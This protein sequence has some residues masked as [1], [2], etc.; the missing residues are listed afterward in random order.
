MTSNMIDWHLPYYGEQVQSCNSEE[1]LSWYELFFWFWSSTYILVKAF[2]NFK[3]LSNIVYVE[4]HLVSTSRFTR[5]W[6]TILTFSSKDLKVANLE[7]EDLTYSIAHL[8]WE[9]DSILSSSPSF[10]IKF[11]IRALYRICKS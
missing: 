7:E 4:F 11:K 5:P 8:I 6:V 9:M 1:F 2:S 10:T 3:V